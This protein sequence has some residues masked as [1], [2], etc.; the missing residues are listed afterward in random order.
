MYSIFAALVKEVKVYAFEPESN[1]FQTLMQ[2]IADNNLVDLISPFPIGISDKTELSKFG[3]FLFLLSSSKDYQ[4]IKSQDVVNS[5]S[6][7]IKFD[8]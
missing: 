1:N 5:A 8:F 6:A 7:Y 2:N 3:D 4:H